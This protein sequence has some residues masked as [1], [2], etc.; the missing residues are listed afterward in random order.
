M[1]R[2][3]SEMAKRKDEDT[4]RKTGLMYAA[5]MSLVF[6]VLTCLLGGLALDEVFDTSP[7]LVVVG[8]IVG[9]IVGFYQF[10]RLVSRVK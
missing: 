1:K 9:A 7:T 10:I 2:I 5:V 6:S 4:T 8:I 3:V